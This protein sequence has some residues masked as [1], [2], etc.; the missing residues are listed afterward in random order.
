[1]KLSPAQ[2]RQRH[3]TQPL[4]RCSIKSPST[5]DPRE[6]TRQTRAGRVLKTQVNTGRDKVS[7]RLIAQCHATCCHTS[8]TF[9]CAQQ[10]RLATA[11]FREFSLEDSTL[12]S[13]LTLLR[14]HLNPST[15][16]HPHVPGYQRHTSIF[17]SDITKA[18]LLP[19]AQS[20]RNAP[21]PYSALCSSRSSRHI[22]IRSVPG[23]QH[24]ILSTSLHRSV[25]LM[26]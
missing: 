1:M 16:Q 18:R 9:V 22:R 4:F 7:S 11:V 23:A 13:V 12:K 2:G 3:R 21:I 14:E 15:D 6:G 20:I 17:L 25:T 5:A 26:A 24:S 19:E 10:W 8:A